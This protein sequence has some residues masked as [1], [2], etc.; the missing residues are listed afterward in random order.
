[1]DKNLLHKLITFTIIIVVGL[2][3]WQVIVNLL[4]PPAAPANTRVTQVMRGTVDPLLNQ[5]SLTLMVQRQDFTEAELA[6]FEIYLEDSVAAANSR[7]DML[8]L[9]YLEPS[10]PLDL[11]F[12]RLREIMAEATMSAQVL[13]APVTPNF[14][15][16]DL[17][18]NNL[19]AQ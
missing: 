18:A 2:V 12:P 15:T 13:G 5:D 10:R 6:Q 17:G 9:Q 19:G 4:A 8:Y 3:G 7:E 11:Y 14:V 16:G 1:M